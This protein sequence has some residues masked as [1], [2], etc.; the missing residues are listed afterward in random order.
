MQSIASTINIST[1]VMAADMIRIVDLGA[2]LSYGVA[3]T[4]QSETENKETSRTTECCAH[5]SRLMAGGAAF[6]RGARVRGLVAIAVV[7][8][9]GGLNEGDQRR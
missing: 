2:K 6:S 8:C 5:S 9:R 3:L 4:I 7:C 1:C